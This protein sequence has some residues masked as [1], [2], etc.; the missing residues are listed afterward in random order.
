MQQRLLY[1]SFKS[2]YFNE[3]MTINHTFTKK[4]FFSPYLSSSLD[5]LQTEL[6]A[7]VVGS[8]LNVI[9]NDLSRFGIS[10]HDAGYY[11]FRK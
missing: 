3:F 2:I 6:I 1:L 10:S 11:E 4:T 7:V 9:K 5:G 8:Q